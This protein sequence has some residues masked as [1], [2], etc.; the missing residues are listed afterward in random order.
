MSSDLF[1]LAGK[2]VTGGRLNA[3]M[4]LATTSF[5][6]SDPILTE[7]DAGTSQMVFTIRRVGDNSG[8]VTVD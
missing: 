8:N 7:G 2:T 6:I 4:A 5:S 3:A 1:S